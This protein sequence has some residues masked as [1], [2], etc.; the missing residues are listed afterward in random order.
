VA[1]AFNQLIDQVQRMGRYLGT[2]WNSAGDKIA[3]ALER[4]DAS[5]DLER[6][7][8]RIKLVRGSGVSGYRGA[9]PLDAPFSEIVCGVADAPPL[10]DHATL[11]AAD[12]SQIYPDPHAPALYYLINTGVFTYYHGEPRLPSQ[13]SAPQLYYKQSEIEDQDGRAINNQTVNARRTVEEMKRLAELAA[14]LAADSTA[15]RPLIALH[16]GGLLKFFGASEIADAKRLETDY[17]KA[18]RALSET[19]AVLAGYPGAQRASYVIALLH[20]LSL[21]PEHVNDANLKT[22]GDLEGLTDARFYA[23]ILLPGQRSALMA[24]NSPQNLEYKKREPAFEIAFFYLNVAEEGEAP[25]I[26]RIDVPMWVAR[27]PAAVDALHALLLQ[28]CAIQGRKRYPYALTRADELAVVSGH[29]RAQVDQLIRIAM[30][31][32]GLTPE[33]SEKL[34]TKGLARGER[35]QHRIKR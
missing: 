35:R 9:A 29:E 10:P 15:Y 23:E 25:R 32:N 4:F 14:E 16:D 5:C 6:V 19:G 12:G 31:E 20:L 30:L 21:A 11:I 1:V 34:Q 28:Q 33:E 13:H 8:E 17:F 26:A 7:Q 2:R 24:Q 22:N 18:L 3:L 27:E